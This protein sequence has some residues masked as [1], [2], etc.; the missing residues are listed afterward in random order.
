MG[1]T[2]PTVGPARLVAAREDLFYPR[3]MLAMLRDLVAH[4][5]HA[6]AAILTAVGQDE[7]A[8]ADREIVD[9]LNHILVAN[10]F[11]V[12]AVR[13]VP[14]GPDEGASRSWDALVAAYQTTHDEEVAWLRSATETDCAAVLEHPLIPGGQCSVAQAYLQVCLHSQGHRAQLAKL[15]RR[16]D[17]L[18]PQTDFVVWLT[19]RP[20]PEW[21]L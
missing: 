15:L 4:K 2:R 11:W 10:R 18:P 14:F 3:V 20:A 9:L 6:N 13:R 21:P 5:G 16:N 7:R 19:S 12:C 8:A 17:V 1:T